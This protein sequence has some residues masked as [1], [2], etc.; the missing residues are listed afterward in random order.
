MNLDQSLTLINDLS[1]EYR[2]SGISDAEEKIIVGAW[3]GENYECIAVQSTFSRKY[4]QNK[5]APM[6]WDFLTEVLGTT[7]GK[8]NLKGYFEKLSPMDIRGDVSSISSFVGRNI[9]LRELDN[10]ISKYRC[11][12]LYGPGGIGKTALMSQWISNNAKAQTM[13]K[14]VIWKTTNIGSAQHLITEVIKESGHFV[15]ESE[16]LVQQFITVLAEEKLLVCIDSAEELLSPLYGSIEWTENRK[17]MKAIVEQ[18]H[19]SCVVFISRQLMPELKLLSSKGLSVGFLR[20]KGLE[21]EEAKQIFSDHSLKDEL[22][23]TKLIQRYAGNPLALKSISCYLNERFS[24]SVSFIDGLNSIV[25]GVEMEQLLKA[26]CETLSEKQR[27]IMVY[28]ATA[29]EHGSN[30]NCYTLSQI[31]KACTGVGWI[32]I[33]ELENM[34]L[35]ERCPDKDLAWTLQPLISKFVRVTPLFTQVAV[36]R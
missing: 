17:L 36:L 22:L 10:L 33:N 30:E 31:E 35:V 5:L 7:V 19:V 13:W 2:G 12:E 32:E 27:M 11:V 14:K 8:M 4:L 34:F 26:Q 6:L 3:H 29:K 16:N 23:W 20:L 1:I 28:L 24:G 18:P 15:I 21:K 25:M 9:E